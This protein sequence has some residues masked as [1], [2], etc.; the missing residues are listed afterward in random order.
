MLADWEVYAKE[1][2]VKKEYAEQIKD[3]LRLL[4]K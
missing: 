4:R 2:D 1:A 3:A